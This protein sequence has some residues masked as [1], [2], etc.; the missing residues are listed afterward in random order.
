MAALETIRRIGFELDP[1]PTEKGATRAKRA[2]KGVGDQAQRTSGRIKKSFVGLGTKI[3]AAF[4]AI[5]ITAFFTKA[6]KGASDLETAL[7]KVSKVTGFTAKQTEDLKNRVRD[8]SRVLPSSTVDLLD[9]S[10]AAA[11]LGVKGVA[12]I[13]NFTDVVSRLSQ[14]TD[15]VGAEGAKQIARVLNVTG[16]GTET[17]ENFA[18]SLVRLGNNFAATEAEILKMTLELSKATGVFGVSSQ[19]AQALGASLISLGVQP[20]LAGTSVG[21]VFIA[22]NNVLSEGGA[23][24]QFLAKVMGRSAESINRDFRANAIGVFQEFLQKVSDAEEQGLSLLEEFGVTGARVAASL[25]PLANNM[26][27]YGRAINLAASASG[28]LRK[29]SDR[30]NESFASQVQLMKNEFAVIMQNIG[31]AILPQVLA[32]VQDLSAAAN[33]LGNEFTTLGTKAAQGAAIAAEAFSDFAIKKAAALAVHTGVIGPRLGGAIV[34]TVEGN[35]AAERARDEIEQLRID[36]QV[37]RVEQSRIDEQ[38]ARV[39]NNPSNIPSS[40]R[41]PDSIPEFLQRPNPIATGVGPQSDELKKMIKSGIPK[42]VKAKVAGGV[43]AKVVKS[44][45]D[46]IREGIA[47]LREEAEL[48]G[49]K[50][51]E[52]FAAEGFEENLARVRMAMEGTFNPEFFADATAELEL[53]AD[54]MRDKVEAG[55]VS[56]G[57]AFKFGLLERIKDLGNTSQQAFEFAQRAFDTVGDAIGD[58]FTDMITGTKSVSDAFRDMA[59]SILQD[60][61]EMIIRQ[62]VFNA[63]SG[64]IGGGSGGIFTSLFGAAGG[65]TSNATG[66]RTPGG[67]GVPYDLSQ[68]ARPGQ[69]LAVVEDNELILRPQD[70]DAIG[71]MGGS[72]GG[73][74]GNMV[75]VNTTVTVNSDGSK[76]TETDDQETGGNE[77]AGALNS[78]IDDRIG[79]L[80]TTPGSPLY[81]G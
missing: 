38:A 72:G 16:E 62:Q 75:V 11:Q 51:K 30:V 29:E 43:K 48:A 44:E 74:R 23:K 27:S 18:D 47:K 21:K 71:Q 69:S 65:I 60:L 4:S 35:S 9:I 67:G 37:A 57:E 66:R 12:N 76:E 39:K 77:I 28:D 13:V 49:Y 6:V 73:G 56:A 1:R 5:A 2:I 64:A 80:M 53:L 26:E 45:L 7:I 25:L 17:I 79:Q 31:A 10:A 46:L 36:E 50:A 61:A 19:E 59:V 78:A 41:R 40:L 3:S 33:I 15:V 81:I 20:E 54:V 58:G 55:A 32:V 63:L 68:G 24:A 22:L 52:A 70:L 42:T 8:L 34:N 14:A